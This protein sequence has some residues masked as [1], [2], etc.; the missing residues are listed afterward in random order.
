MDMWRIDGSFFMNNKVNME[1]PD[2]PLALVREF[3][4]PRVSKEGREVYQKYVALYG[5]SPSVLRKMVTSNG[6][7]VVAAYIRE[8]DLLKELL[9]I[10]DEIIPFHS[11]R[12]ARLRGVLN[13]QYEKIRIFHRAICLL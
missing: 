6:V 3:S 5:P 2:L 8:R 11:T 10:Y 7:S 1:L 13:E 9:L 4:R 12:A